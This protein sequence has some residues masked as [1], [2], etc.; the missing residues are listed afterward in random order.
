MTPVRPCLGGTIPTT[1]GLLTFLSLSSGVSAQTVVEGEGLSARLVVELNSEATP[2]VPSVVQ[3]VLRNEAGGFLVSHLYGEPEIVIHGPNGRFVRHYHEVGD[4]PGELR[5][6]PD[7]VAGPEG[8]I[9]AWDMN[10]LHRFDSTLRHERTLYLDHRMWGTLVVL[11]EGGIV[12]DDQF[13]TDAG[14]TATVALLDDAGTFA[15]VVESEEAPLARTL[16]AP[17]ADGGF[18]TL[19]PAGTRLRKYDSLGTRVHE[20]TISGGV[21]EPWDERIEGEGI[22]VRPRPQHRRLV[23]PGGGT[24]LVLAWVAAP[25]WAP[26]D[27]T[28]AEGWLVPSEFDLNPTWHAVVER[29]D[30]QSGRVVGRLEMPWALERVQGAPGLF[31]SRH[32]TQL[33]HVVTRIWEVSA[34]DPSGGPR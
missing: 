24:L 34:A 10:R 1:L 32:P 33:G 25:D 31:H 11:R 7:L 16:L 21:V 17:S 9:Y 2:A 13:P 20:A 8:S 6:F 4:G 12:V 22:R 15:R 5:M 18:W 27:P 29:V 26:R 28:N 23:D 3:S 30:A 14:D 19:S